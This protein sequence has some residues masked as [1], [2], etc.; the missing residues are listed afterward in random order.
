M[1]TRRGE[2]STMLVDMVEGMTND[3]TRIVIRLPKG[4]TTK[5][6]DEY[7]RV[8][9]LSMELMLTEIHRLDILG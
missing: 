8:L 7:A 5:T 6:S 3:E 9:G 1:A 2:V 4:T